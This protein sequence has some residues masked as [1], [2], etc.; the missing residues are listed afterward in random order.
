MPRPRKPRCCQAFAG[1]RVFKPRSIPMSQ[2]ETIR[3]ELSELEALR[4]CDLERLDQDAA[5]AQMGVSRGTV[6]RLL[7]SG[8][9]K[10]VDAILGSHALLIEKGESD[11]DL[12]SD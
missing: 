2:L 9:A 11:E 6:Q 12:Y 3:L 10:V 8:R 7:K 1:D 5:G 4:L